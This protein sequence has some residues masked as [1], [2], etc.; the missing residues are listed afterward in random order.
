[1]EPYQKW[2]SPPDPSIS[3]WIAHKE[4]QVDTNQWILKGD[5]Y[6]AWKTNGTLFWVRGASEHLRHRFRIPCH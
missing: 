1:V 2:L 5:A 3:H 4:R 6:K